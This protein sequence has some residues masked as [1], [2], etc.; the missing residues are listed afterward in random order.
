MF[1]VTKLGELVNIIDHF[2][3]YPLLTKKC[4]DFYYLK[5]LLII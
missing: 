2:N 3:L 1:Q 4:A 5:K